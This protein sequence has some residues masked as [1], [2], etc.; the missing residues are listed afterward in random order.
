N[1]IDTYLILLKP[2]ET[3]P[4]PNTIF[5]DDV[6]PG[7]NTNSRI[8]VSG[9]ITLPETGTYSI[10]ANLFPDPNRPLTGDYQLTLTFGGTGT[11]CPPTPT[12]I[13]N[14]QTLTGVLDA[15]D[16]TLQD[17]SPYDAY[18]FAATAGQQVSITMTAPQ[19]SSVDPYLILLAP[20][21]A[22][23][24]EDDGGGGGVNARIP[25]S[26]GVAVLPQTGTYTIYA[27]TAA[28]GQTGGYSITLNVAGT[29]PST[30]L[31]VG[32]T[33]GGMLD[34]GDCR[35]PADGSFL[36][37]YTFAG[38]QG[39]QLSVSMAASSSGL[40]P[41]LF[42]LSPTGTELAADNNGGG[43]TTARIPAGGGT[44]TLP[45]TGTYTLYANSAAANQ[46]GGYTLSLLPPPI[47]AGQVLISELR[48][49][50]PGAAGGGSLLDDYVELQNVSSV[51]VDLSG[52]K[53]RID[54]GAG[55]VDVVINSG[56]LL[57]PGRHY[58]LAN[59]AAGSYSLAAYAAP[60]Q[61]YAADLQAGVAL[62]RPDNSVLDQVGRGVASQVFGEGPRLSAA[63]GTQ[64]QTCFVRQLVTGLPQDTDN[65]APDFALVAAAP[66]LMPGATLGAPGPENRGAP[67]QR[68]ATVKATLIDPG[69]AATGTGTPAGGCQNRVRLSAP[70]PAAPALSPNGQ[71]LIRRRFVNMTGQAVTRLRFRVVDI[72]TLNSPGAGAT[73]A[74]LR[75]LSSQDITITR[76]DGGGAVDVKGLTLEQPPAQA[77]GGGLN[78]TLAAGTITTSA[79]LPAGASV[80]VEF[81]LGVVQGGTYR[82]LVN[83]EAAP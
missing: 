63:D 35:L 59:A 25:A 76:G 78:S 44:F 67:A 16:C 54:T 29:C 17:G 64:T 70:D 32:Q 56:A 9:F 6:A 40:D 13:S 1:Q 3:S 46:T 23:I 60:D 22:D 58:L 71:L 43:G 10:L 52:S 57:P 8:P 24:A 68:N 12:A 49:E 83:V 4:G 69:C 2:S 82:F 39:Q 7:S 36:D 21:G 28:A 15:N 31:G 73:Q 47:P 27:N 30:P 14:G 77:Q 20:D 41:F 62:A 50:G 75:V 19:G 33:V 11:T 51:T 55:V 53:L 26:S 74:D 66:A 79:A 42:L 38:T 61:T 48:F 72:T 37:V 5:N 34:A 18:S 45:A 80:A 65:N 81:R